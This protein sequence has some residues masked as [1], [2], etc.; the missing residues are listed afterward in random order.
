MGWLLETAGFDVVTIVGGY[1]AYRTHVMQSFE[2]R[3]LKMMIL[4]GK[5]GCGKTLILKE[6]QKA[7]EQIIDLE[8]LA[9]HKGSAFGWIGELPQPTVEQ[10]ENN[11]FEVF[12]QLDPNR[13]VWVENESRTIGSSVIPAGFWAQMKAATLVH[14]EV[15]NETRIKHLVDIYTQTN[16]ADL[17]LSFEKIEKKLGKEALKNATEALNQGDFATATQI[18]LKYYDK[19]YMQLFD[20]NPIVQKFVL[21]VGNAAPNVAARQLMDWANQHKM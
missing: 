11:L 19:I 18:A 15:P 20:N 5:T 16:V 6:L 1:K 8:G 3:P 12:R 13:R 10:F 2:S 21:N 7:G 4:G 17:I 14:L 9:H